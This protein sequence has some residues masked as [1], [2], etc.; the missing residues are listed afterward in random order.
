[1]TAKVLPVCVAIVFTSVVG[2]VF[3][4]PAV[5]NIPLKVNPT[6]NAPPTVVP[7]TANVP[8]TRNEEPNAVAVPTKPGDMSAA[9]AVVWKNFDRADCP[10]AART[11]R[12]SDGTV[13][14]FCSNGEDFRVDFNGPFATL[15]RKPVAIRCSA[16][17]DIGVGC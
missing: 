1:M 2:A 5:I 11:Q 3:A 10:S 8:A 12:L 14:I 7:P 17:R 16:A 15:A 4:E 6:V 13:K 9:I